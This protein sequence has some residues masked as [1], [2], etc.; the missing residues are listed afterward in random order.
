MALTL[1]QE[2]TI[3]ELANLLERFLPANPHPYGD[4]SLSFPAIA[5]EYKLGEIF[6]VGNKKTKITNFLLKAYE[7]CNSDFWKIILEIIKRGRR[8]QPHGKE[9]ILKE[10]IISINQCLLK[11]KVK[12]PELWNKEFL[13]KL[14]SNSKSDKKDTDKKDEN[15]INQQN[16]SSEIKIQLKEKLFKISSQNPQQRGFDFEIFLKD[17]FAAYNLDPNGSFRLT[18]EQID[19]SFVLDGETYLIEAKWEQGQ[20]NA[21]KLNAFHSKLSN[22]AWARGVFISY[23]G[24]TQDA[25][26]VYLTGKT[27]NLITLDSSEIFY[28]LD[29]SQNYKQLSLPDVLRQKVRILNEKNIFVSALEL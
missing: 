6:N 1:M 26:Q 16:V 2:D 19:G 5:N 23:N 17:L 4:Q 18:G 9:P 11:L 20:V 22:R 15:T 3:S 24:F 25:Y 8:H 10:E 14:P 28:I 29:D 12:I 13:D 21:Q 7:H 27:A